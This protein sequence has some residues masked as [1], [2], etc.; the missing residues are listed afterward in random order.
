MGHGMAKNIRLKI[1][2]SSTLVIYDINE[3][4]MHQFV[5]D[6]EKYGNIVEAAS[7]KEVAEKA[8]SW[9]HETHLKVLVQETKLQFYQYEKAIMRISRIRN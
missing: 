4:A 2:M 9:T 7:P 5:K 6:Y 1:A 8:V 3:D